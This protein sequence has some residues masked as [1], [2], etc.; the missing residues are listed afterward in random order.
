[1]IFSDFSMVIHVYLTSIVS[2]N[3]I[4]KTHG[5]GMIFI[6]LY[7]YNVVFIKFLACKNQQQKQQFQPKF[8][9]FQVQGFIK[10]EPIH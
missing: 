6:V 10:N 8:H 9:M 1:M 4:A 5:A 2:I 7:F 3:F